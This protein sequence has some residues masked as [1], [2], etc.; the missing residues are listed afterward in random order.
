[1]RPVVR[2]RV[3]YVCGAPE[4]GAV[5]GDQLRAGRGIA[6]RCQNDLVSGADELFGE[7]GDDCLGPAIRRGRHRLPERGQLEDTQT[8]S[9][10]QKVRRRVPPSAIGDDGIQEYPI[11]SRAIAKTPVDSSI[12]LSTLLDNDRLLWAGYPHIRT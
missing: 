1:M 3:G 10:R 8:G 2:T 7:D 5:N 6:S 12:P 4:T 11:R 9:P